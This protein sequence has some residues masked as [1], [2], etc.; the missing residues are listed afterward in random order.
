MS[1]APFIISRIRHRHKQLTA[2][3]C[4]YWHKTSLALHLGK[5]CR[6]PMLG[7]GAIKEYPCHHGNY[8]ESTMRLS[9][10][11]AMAALWVTGSIV[12]ITGCGGAADTVTITETRE[13]TIARTAPAA[14][15]V[16]GSTAGDSGPIM[17][18]VDESQVEAVA[19]AATAAFDREWGD[20]SGVNVVW[21]PNIIS[22]WAL[23]GLENISGAAGKD[24]L[25]AQE[26]GTWQVKD[27]GHALSVQWEGQ[28]PQGLWPTM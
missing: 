5:Y 4:H 24:V 7:S 23:I 9:W 12:A 21:G 1:A 25:L 8:S 6:L 28:T 18:N 14:R 11:K 13:A 2:Y 3:L 15:S 20:G 17:P 26:N 27:M 22:G 10:K 16:S 19:L